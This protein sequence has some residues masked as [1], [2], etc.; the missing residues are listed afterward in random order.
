M[1][2]C[3]Q[4]EASY[5]DYICNLLDHAQI[6]LFEVHL[7]DC[8]TCRKEIKALKEVLRLTDSAET[9]I[10]STIW[11]LEDIDMKVY[12]RLAAESESTSERPVISRV[13]RLL[14]FGPPVSSE[15]SFTYEL[16]SIVSMQIWG[17]ML[18][19]GTLFLALIIAAIFFDGDQSANPPLTSFRVVPTSE[20]IEQYRSQGIHQSLEDAL[21][22]RHLRNDEWETASQLRILNEQAQGTR[23]ES[24]T[25]QQLQIPL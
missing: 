7:Q 20:R 17:G 10:S 11:A 4:H 8:S 1:A 16:S 14:R 19:R 25:N 24:M 12:K 22:V 5:I 21:V 6:A 15:L 13:R 3:K 2:I 9:E 23:F 18:A